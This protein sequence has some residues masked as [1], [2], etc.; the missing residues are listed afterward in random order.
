MITTADVLTYLSE[1]IGYW[2]EARANADHPQHWIAVYYVDAYQRAR[3]TLL[4]A[5]LPADD[6]Q[7]VVVTHPIP[8]L[9]DLEL[10]D[11]EGR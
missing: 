2:R 1:Q 8:R 9:A 7:V 6:E 5:R 4:G 10:L 11:E 3:E